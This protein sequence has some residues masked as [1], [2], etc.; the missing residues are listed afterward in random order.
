[1]G[2]AIRKLL[3][4]LA[5]SALALGPPG[6]RPARADAPTLEHQV[7]SA[8]VVNF[9]QFIDWP[10]A[11]FDKPDDPLIIGLVDGGGMGQA[12]TAAVEGKTV[13]GHKLV[14]REFT[15]AT[16]GKCHVLV[17]GGLDGAA[18][19]NAAKAAGGAGVLTIGDSDR[20]TDS[21]GVIRFYL[22]DGKLRF[23]INLAAAQRAQLQISSKLLKLARVV[24]Q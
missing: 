12:M 13:R 3:I 5:G 11:S 16:V 23:E 4:L 17:V 24:N 6:A 21:G 7:K 14:I 8:F 15:A 20:F 9:I 19:Q 2:Q 18:L 10:A 1:M 22:E